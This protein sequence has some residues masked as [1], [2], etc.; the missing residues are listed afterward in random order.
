VGGL[1]VVRRM[2]ERLPEESIVYIGDT[3]HVPYGGKSAK[4]L[5]ELGERIVSF[6]IDKGAK[7]IV[8]SAGL[9]S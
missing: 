7:V 5:L 4:E 3:A 2:R 9:M 8:A 6:L 1:S